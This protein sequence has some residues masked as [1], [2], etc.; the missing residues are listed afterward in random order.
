MLAN[1]LAEKHTFDEAHRCLAIDEPQSPSR[2]S[3]ARG[4]HQRQKPGVLPSSTRPFEVPAS[5][6]Y[7]LPRDG[8]IR[9]PQLEEGPQDPARA[10]L[11][12]EIKPDLE[13]SPDLPVGP[14]AGQVR[15]SSNRSPSTR[16]GGAQALPLSNLPV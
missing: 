6:W 11:I 8:L 9:D 7:A 10:K 5:H 2:R 12:G 4:V 13:S 3:A 14:E 15:S 1:V 16:G